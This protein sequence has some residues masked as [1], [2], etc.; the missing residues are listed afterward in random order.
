MHGAKGVTNDKYGFTSVDLKHVG[1]KSEP[2]ILAKDVCQVFYVT[3]TTDAM[4]FSLGKDA[5]LEMQTSLMRRSS[6]NSM[7]SSLLLL[8][9]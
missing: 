5:S 8:Q 9:L 6:I 7:K 3:D 1:Y 2:F 4:W